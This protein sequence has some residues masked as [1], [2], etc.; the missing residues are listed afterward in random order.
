MP[1]TPESGFQPNSQIKREILEALDKGKPDFGMLKATEGDMTLS[2]SGQ[3][4][5]SLGSSDTFKAIPQTD[6]DNPDPDDARLTL[7]EYFN[8]KGV[9]DTPTEEGK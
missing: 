3:G 9:F 7:F 5:A 1:E 2:F 6:P 8:A 4:F